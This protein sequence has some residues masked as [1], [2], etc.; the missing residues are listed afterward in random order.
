MPIDAKNMSKHLF[1]ICEA[2]KLGYSYY[3]MRP[4]IRTILT[5]KEREFAFQTLPLL[6]KGWWRE[7]HE[8]DSTRKSC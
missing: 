6:P 8:W 3:Y 1:K 5:T 2:V 7:R 4:K